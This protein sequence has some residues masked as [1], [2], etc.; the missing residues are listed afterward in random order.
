MDKN[1]LKKRKK[2]FGNVFFGFNKRFKQV[3]NVEK[4]LNVNI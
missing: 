1:E 2:A 4:Y 3:K